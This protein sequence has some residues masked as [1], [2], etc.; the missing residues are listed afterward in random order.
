MKAGVHEEASSVQSGGRAGECDTVAVTIQVP[1][2]RNVTAVLHRVARNIP[3]KCACM[4]TAPGPWDLTT[5]PS[6]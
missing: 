3:K 4:L 5:Q 2:R 1:K 6:Q